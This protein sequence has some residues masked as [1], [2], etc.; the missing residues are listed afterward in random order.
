M[1][2]K[3]TLQEF[4]NY[5]IS[6]KEHHSLTPEERLAKEINT[7][8]VDDVEDNE[9]DDFDDEN[10]GDN[11]EYTLDE[12]AVVEISVEAIRLSLDLSKTVLN[13]MTSVG[14]R[15]AEKQ[16]DDTDVVKNCQSVIAIMVDSVA[17]LESQVTDLGAELYP[18]VESTNSELIAH[19]N[20]LVVNMQ[21][22]FSLLKVETIV[23]N[24]L[25]SEV[26]ALATIGQRLNSCN[27]W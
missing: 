15:I 22:T 20:L 12:L 7:L 9:D 19:Y 24:L 13:I 5:I 17:V 11:S 14:D 6:A 23:T 3:E 18:P 4:E 1:A 27:G 25:E 2:I 16:S 26:K 10:E 8:T 21:H